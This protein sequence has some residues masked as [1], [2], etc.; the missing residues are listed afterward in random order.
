MF[1][2][3]S[4]INKWKKVTGVDYLMAFFEQIFEKITPIFSIKL[5]SNALLY[6]LLEIVNINIII[7]S[8]IIT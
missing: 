2:R 4:V 3:R 1:T 7:S 8:N 6:E 5:K